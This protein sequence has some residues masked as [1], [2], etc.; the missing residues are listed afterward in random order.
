MN[1]QEA[2]TCLEMAMRWH[3]GFTKVLQTGCE[4]KNK[5]I[6]SCQDVTVDNLTQEE[7]NGAIQLEIETLGKLRIVSV[8][9]KWLCGF[10]NYFFLFQ[11][12][13]QKLEQKMK[14]VFQLK[15]AT[16]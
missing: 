8:V 14:M 9:A 7:L 3:N 12:I 13:L 11:N 5:N 1:L 16:R 2:I 6:W 4:D 15:N 10:N